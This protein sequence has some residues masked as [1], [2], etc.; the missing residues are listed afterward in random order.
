MRKIMKLKKYTFISALLFITPLC[1]MVIE[2]E[3]KDDREFEA[4]YDILRQ[5]NP[6]KP[7]NFLS[8]SKYLGA[9]ASINSKL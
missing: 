3:M 4:L 9:I 5:Q 7:V 6:D 2:R 8:L 1:S